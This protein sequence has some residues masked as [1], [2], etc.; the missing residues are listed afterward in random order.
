MLQDISYR[1]LTSLL[2]HTVRLSIGLTVRR[3]HDLCN[4]WNPDPVRYSLNSWGSFSYS[5]RQGST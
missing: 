1:T 2:S 4:T 3:L 5:N